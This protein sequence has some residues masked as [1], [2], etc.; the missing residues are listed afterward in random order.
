MTDKKTDET[1]CGLPYEH[2]FHVF[3]TNRDKVKACDGTFRSKKK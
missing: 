2:G 1:E 3:R